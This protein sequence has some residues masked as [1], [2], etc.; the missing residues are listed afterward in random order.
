[1]R[2]SRDK[3]EIKISKLLLEVAVAD[4][5]VKAIREEFQ[6]QV[7]EQIRGTRLAGSQIHVD[8]ELSNQPWP[9]LTFPNPVPAADSADLT[10]VWAD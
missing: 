6:R 5:T 1:M 4:A 3:V 10:F 2:W 9:K 7:E 8:Y